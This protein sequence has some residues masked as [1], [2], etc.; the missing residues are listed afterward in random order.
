MREKFAVPATSAAIIEDNG[1]NEE[2]S[3]SWVVERMSERRERER[4]K[5]RKAQMIG[6]KQLADVNHISKL[7]RPLYV[8]VRPSVRPSISS[9]LFSFFFWMGIYPS[10][11]SYLLTPDPLV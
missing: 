4:K 1:D 11:I 8:P 6:R 7:L 3:A 10:F 9:L 5:E 2:R